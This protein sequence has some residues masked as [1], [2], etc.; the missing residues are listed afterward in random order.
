M[1]KYARDFRRSSS[2]YNLSKAMLRRIYRSKADMEK[3]AC[4]SAESFQY[5]VCEGKIGG[6]GGVLVGP[7]PSVVPPDR[8]ASRPGAGNT[9]GLGTA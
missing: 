2:R 6:A 1:K 9:R 7:H 4:N 5:M 8:R 3:V